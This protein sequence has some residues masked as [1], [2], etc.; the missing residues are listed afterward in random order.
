[1]ACMRSRVRFPQAPHG[2]PRGRVPPGACCGR[3]VAAPDFT[4]GGHHHGD[5]AQPGR[6][7]ASHAAC[8]RFESDLLHVALWNPHEWDTVPCR[9]HGM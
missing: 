1:M 8:R 4:E 5:V 9:L 6:A 7:A 3:D 2:R